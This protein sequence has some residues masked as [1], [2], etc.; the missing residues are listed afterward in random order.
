MFHRVSA[1][2]A[3][4]AFTSVPV[5]AQVEG[6]LLDGIAAVV[7][8]DV[9]L[10]S[11]LDR[12]FEQVRA[13]IA[14][15]GATLPP[16]RLLRQQVLDRLIVERLQLLRAAD[17]GITVSEDI[18]NQAMNSIARNNNMT[19]AEFTR[20]VEE[21]GLVF[22]EIRE[23]VRQDMILNQLRQREVIE[24][25]FVSQREVESFIAGQGAESLDDREYKVAHILLRTAS[26]ASSDETAAI[27]AA[28]EGL[29]ERARA[30]ADFAE[31]AI[32][33]SQGQQALQGGDLGWR[34]LNQLPT[35]FAERLVSMNPGDVAPIIRTAGAF[36]VIKLMDV[37]GERERVVVQQTHARHILIRT[38]PLLTSER[39]A[40]RLA[41]LRERILAGESFE[42]IARRNSD[43]PASA[44]NGGDLGWVTPGDTVGA[45]ESTVDALPV[46]GISEPFQTRFG[47]HI[48]QVLARREYDGTDD[49]RIAQARRILQERKA[50]EQT[51]LWVRRLLEEAYVE[52]RLEG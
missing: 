33:H 20:A 15:S 29:I 28:A 9:V 7:N 30:G 31:L 44:V 6:Q 34:R 23:S 19:L 39:A 27:Q 8:D 11:E 38:N 45:F 42:E 32:A 4:L 51:E 48:V 12:R 22:A 17:V 47:W 3:V 35:V 49:M 16:D 10:L 36:H 26:N 1:V 5:A 43:D 52:N 21:D 14:R 37:R 18:L 41:A 2:L 25:V 24:K 50:E 13:D 46:G 40:A